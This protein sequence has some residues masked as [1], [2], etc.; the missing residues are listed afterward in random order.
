M[1]KKVSKRS[2]PHKWLRFRIFSRLFNSALG[3]G[4]GLG[5]HMGLGG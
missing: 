2:R 5:S 1:S 3:T 4:R